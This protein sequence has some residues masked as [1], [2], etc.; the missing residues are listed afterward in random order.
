MVTVVEPSPVMTSHPSVV[1]A[2]Q[3][4]APSHFSSLTL[5]VSG[6]V[7]PTWRKHQSLAELAEAQQYWK[8]NQYL[9]KPLGFISCSRYLQSRLASYR[10]TACYSGLAVFWHKFNASLYSYLCAV[11]TSRQGK[12]RTLKRVLRV[13]K[14]LCRENLKSKI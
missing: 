11:S 1:R 7:T 8:E 4:K 10:T 13:V 6:S 3:N 2:L 5:T 14:S 9:P 12:H